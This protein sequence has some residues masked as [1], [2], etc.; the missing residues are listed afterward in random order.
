MITSAEGTVIG[1]VLRSILLAI[2]AVVFFLVKFLTHLVRKYIKCCLLVGRF[3][4]YSLSSSG[5]IDKRRTG[6]L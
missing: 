1:L 2:E 3:V 6:A 4:R 5:I